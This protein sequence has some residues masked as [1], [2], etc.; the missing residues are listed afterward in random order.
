LSPWCFTIIKVDIDF[1]LL[2]E[3]YQESDSNHIFYLDTKTAEIINCNDLGGE[4]VDFEKNAEEH[5][6]NPR[7]IE[8][9]TRESRD[10]YFIMTL[11]AYT[12][13]TLQLA[14]QFHTVLEQEK[15]V[16]HFRQLLHNH[17]DVQ[18]KWNEYRYNSLKNEIINWLYDHHLELIDQQLIPEITI[19]ELNRSEIKQLPGELKGF[20]PLACLHCNNK[21][22]LNARWFL[23]SMEPENKLMEQKIKS[24]MKQEFKVGDFG[25]FGG[26]KNH[27]LTAAQCPKCGSEN[28]FWDF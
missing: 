10:D 7:Y 21:T 16:K 3:A 15:P 25:H 4:P 18:K 24:K 20:H 8:V 14:E 22:D 5:E 1:E 6:Q 26:G 27:Y 17:P 2:V 23:C 9:P 11:F 19:T 28:I 12:L 13:P